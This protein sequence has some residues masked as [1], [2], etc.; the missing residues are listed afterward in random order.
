MKT[1]TQASRGN[2]SSPCSTRMEGLDICSREIQAALCTSFQWILPIPPQGQCYQANFIGKKKKTSSKKISN[3]YKVP[4]FML[5]PYSSLSFRGVKENHG[6]ESSKYQ[7]V[8]LRLPS[9]L[10]RCVTSVPSGVFFESTVK[11]HTL[12]L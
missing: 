3:L 11:H 8:M 7:K 6:Q 12:I 10:A 2:Y 4:K 1:A 5:V 9:L